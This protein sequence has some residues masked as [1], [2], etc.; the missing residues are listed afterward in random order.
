MKDE[1]LSGWLLMNRRQFNR[2]LFALG[3]LALS[4]PLAAVAEAFPRPRDDIKQP[5]RGFLRAGS[6]LA[7]QGEPDASRIG[8]CFPHEPPEARR[9]TPEESHLPG[10]DLEDQIREYLRKARND[11]LIDSD[12]VT[13]WSVFD[14]TGGT[15]LVAIKEDVPRECASMV[16]PFVALAFFDCVKRGILAYDAGRRQLLQRMIQNSSNTATNDM[17]DL[18]GGPKAVDAILCRTYPGI[19]RQTKVLEKIPYDGRTYMNQASAHDYSRFLYALWTDGIPYSDE[20]RRLMALPNRD[21][22]Y[23]GVPNIPSGTLI[24]HKTGTTARLCGDFGLLVP[25]DWRGVRYPYT[26]V[27]IVERRDR[28]SDLS[29][30][31]WIGGRLIRDVSAIVY[32][33]MQRRYGLA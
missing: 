1:G 15:K 30:W 23:D 28:A 24:Y 13:S 11:G 8:P 6:A 18:I 17:I 19:F 29:R 33:A 10:T 7:R 12:E 3:G 2:A 21:R 16:K 20:I 5:N 22:L 9:P 32:E 31:V 27:A 4:A 25:R 26:L 14:F